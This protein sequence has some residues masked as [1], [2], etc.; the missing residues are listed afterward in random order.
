MLCNT[1]GSPKHFA[2]QCP[3]GKGKGSEDV[4]AHFGSNDTEYFDFESLFTETE[5]SLLV[6]VY[7]YLDAFDDL[8][9]YMHRLYDN[10]AQLFHGPIA[11][12]QW[13]G[14]EGAPGNGQEDPEDHDD[15][16]SETD[17]EY[18]ACSQE[19][20]PPSIPETI[21]ATQE[22]LDAMDLLGHEPPPPGN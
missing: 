7:T 6:M 8:E 22:E 17:P 12:E 11:F 20:S 9:L 15:D 3:K 4:T 14:I 16:Y 13:A 10:M 5:Q 2:S 1:C 18:D 21:P 19:T